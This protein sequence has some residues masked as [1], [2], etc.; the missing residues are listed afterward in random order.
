[1]VHNFCHNLHPAPHNSYCQHHHDH[2]YHY[3]HHSE[4][5][6]FLQQCNCSAITMQCS[7][8]F[9][10]RFHQAEKTTRGAL[11][12]RGSCT[13]K[14]YCAGRSNMHCIN[15]QHCSALYCIAL[16][17]CCLCFCDNLRWISSRSCDGG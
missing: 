10:L 14:V 4:I 3:H 6:V 11:S 5:L 13:V 16:H 7:A 8:F 17:H 1:M 12:E 2:H 15:L 9:D